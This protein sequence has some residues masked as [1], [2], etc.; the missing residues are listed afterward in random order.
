MPRSP[1]GTEPDFVVEDML[2]QLRPFQAEVTSAGPVAV[3]TTR[4][5]SP[6][7]M[8]TFIPRSAY[9][10]IAG[11]LGAAVIKFWSR[12]LKFVIPKKQIN[13]VIKFVRVCY[14]RPGCI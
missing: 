2:R 7:R 10:D 13:Q 12:D 1:H 14:N 6:A 4:L 9:G 11:V 8:M 5:E 3:R